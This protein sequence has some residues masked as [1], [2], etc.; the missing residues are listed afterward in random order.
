MRRTFIIVYPAS[1]LEERGSPFWPLLIESLQRRVEKADFEYSLRPVHENEILE[2]VVAQLQDAYKEQAFQGVITITFSAEVSEPLA[3]HKIPLVAF[4]GYSDW[5][6]SLDNDY[7]FG[8]GVWQLSRK[9][10]QRIGIWESTGKSETGGGVS[11]EEKEHWP[12]LKQALTFSNLDFHPQLWNEIAAQNDFDLSQQAYELAKKVFSEIDTRPDG[13]IVMNDFITHGMVRALDEIG[14][15][16]G[17]DVY[18]VSSA[19]RGSPVL[20]EC[21]DRIILMEFDSNH[22]AGKIVE[23]MQEQMDAPDSA[24]EH[25]GV[26]PVPRVPVSEKVFRRYHDGVSY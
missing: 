1:L 12:T 2:D 8:A 16:V 24:G 13:L 18:I 7:I 19:N 14:V 22:I 21:Q 9:G 26:R 25:R 4:S 3:L 10:C 6:V 23:L 17:R 11:F 15:K 20:Q 5:S